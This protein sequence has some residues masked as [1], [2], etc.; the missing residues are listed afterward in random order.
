[1]TDIPNATR[2][3]WLYHRLSRV[4]GCQM[5]GLRMLARS[6]TSAQRWALFRNPTA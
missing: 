4:P 6:L 5:L 3:Q 1:M 2:L